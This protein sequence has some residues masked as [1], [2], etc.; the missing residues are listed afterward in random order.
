MNIKQISEFETGVNTKEAKKADN[1]QNELIN[2]NHDQ[3]KIFVIG[4]YCS[5]THWLNYLF[6]KNTPKNYLYTLRNQH[7]YLDDNNNVQN[8]FKHGILKEKLINQKNIVIIYTIR[9]FDTFLT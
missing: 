6:I 7:Q 4:N 9:N 2:I 5:G 8:N 3:K 1:E